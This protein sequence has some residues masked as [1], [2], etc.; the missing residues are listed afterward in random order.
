[1]IDII[2]NNEKVTVTGVKRLLKGSIGQYHCH[3][4]F[5]D[6][7]AEYD[8]HVIFCAGD[9][10]K[11]VKIETLSEV[12]EIPSEI[13]NDAGYLFISSVGICGEKQ[14]FTDIFRS[15]PIVTGSSVEDV[16]NPYTMMLK[17]EDYLWQAAY[18]ELN[19]NAAKRYFE[20]H[21]DPITGACSAVRKGD[22]VLG[23]F[24]W[25]FNK[26]S[27]FVVQVSGN[28]WRPESIGVAGGVPE[29]TDEFVSSGKYSLMYDILPFYINSGINEYGVY[30][31]TNVVPMEKN[32]TKSEPLLER[33][34]DV[35]S[36]ALV[37]FVMDNFA[38]A[39][40]AV[41]YIRDYTLVYFPKTLNEMGYQQHFMIADKTD[42]F[43]LEF[44]N[45]HAVIVEFPYMTNF[46]IDGVS[47]DADGLVLTPESQV[48]DDTAETVNHVTPHGSGLER[49]NLI[50]ERYSLLTDKAAMEALAN[51]LK[52]TNAY[53]DSENEA[54][55]KWLTEFVEGDLTV[56]SPAEYFE[57]AYER[58]GEEYAS[59]SRETGTTWQTVHA[60][61]YDLVK[62]EMTLFSQES[63]T[64]R[65]FK[66]WGM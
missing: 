54:N 22:L 5:D 47:T 25:F 64:K 36:L 42:T 15:I 60:A 7:W 29:L 8:R 59:R 19:Y 31:K 4:Q 14:R 23:T 50:A 38:S 6:S 24:D 13:L 9:K 51:D 63:D 40:D 45:D 52:Y 33:R 66:I 41:N 49:F 10:K 34:K 65:T 17:L 11:S 55:P 48:G 39:R 1:M 26:Q 2:V 12:I 56:G 53:K 28:P 57:A 32:S 21:S 30:A 35:S 58:A 44:V 46:H 62:L 61:I 37:R 43:I 18:K 27:S 16:D 3:V 20:E